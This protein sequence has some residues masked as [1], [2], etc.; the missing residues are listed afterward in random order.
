MIR[1]AKALKD[2]LQGGETVAILDPHNQRGAL[3]IA[4]T[5]ERVTPGALRSLIERGGAS[6]VARDLTGEPMQW[7]AA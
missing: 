5:G 1:T 3:G 2:A 4:A 6:V 7:G